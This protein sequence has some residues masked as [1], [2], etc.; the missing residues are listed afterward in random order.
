METSLLKNTHHL[1]A[2]ASAA[3]DTRPCSCIP[4]WTPV[5]PS[6]PS[7]IPDPSAGA[8]VPHAERRAAPS[9][10]WRRAGAADARLCAGMRR[11]REA[12]DPP[13]RTHT[14]VNYWREGRAASDGDAC[15]QGPCAPTSL[16]LSLSVSR[17]APASPVGLLQWERVWGRLL[18]SSLRPETLHL[19]WIGAAAPPLR[20]WADRLN[21]I[22][23]VSGWSEGKH[24]G[25]K[26]EQSWW[27]P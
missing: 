24:T 4:V 13:T 12:P 26:K 11:G 10:A 25:F 7:E 1:P 27:R 9:A 5:P 8:C 18:S 21:T 17:G 16:S 19:L 20:C 14:H 3:S 23:L 22:Y 6:E 2:P 15:E